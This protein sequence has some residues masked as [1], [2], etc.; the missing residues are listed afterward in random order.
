MHAS[1]SRLDVADKSSKTRENEMNRTNLLITSAVIA[2]VATPGASMAQQDRI[3]QQEHNAPAQKVA[4]QNAPAV[5]NQAPNGRVGEPQ[6]R[7]RT[8]TTGQARR[9]GQQNRQ[10]DSNLEQERGKTEQPPRSPRDEK[11]RTTGQAPRDDRLNRGSEQNRTT[12]QA[13]RQD[14]TNRPPEQNGLEQERQRTDRPEEN[15]ATTGQGVAGTR[16]DINLTQDKRTR[17]RQVIVEKPNAPR[18]S[19]PNFRVSVG[20]R[21]PRTLHFAALPQTIV[22]IEPAW[23]GF[24]YFLINDQI[25]I[26]DPR[27]MEIVAIVET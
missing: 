11:N 6:G 4:P 5:H 25:V 22:E 27:S 7:D 23:R 24:D 8:E 2:L 20:A 15:R 19:R 13:P 12:G 3:P 10:S 9:E 1:H 14:R 21:V 26:V 17:I 18:V 16:A